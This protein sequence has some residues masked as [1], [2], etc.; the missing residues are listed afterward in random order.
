MFTYPYN[1]INVNKFNGYAVTQ[2]L[3]FCLVGVRWL[4]L[5]T[6]RLFIFLSESIMSMYK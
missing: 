2:G 1:A 6:Y 5:A 4:G 3:L